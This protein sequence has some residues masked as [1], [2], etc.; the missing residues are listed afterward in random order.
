[1]CMW[2]ICAGVSLHGWKMLGVFA[3]IAGEFLEDFAFGESHTFTPIVSVACPQDPVH[4]D[5][6]EFPTC[7]TGSL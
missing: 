2:V 3:K 5:F 4:P 1:M 6:L 7:P